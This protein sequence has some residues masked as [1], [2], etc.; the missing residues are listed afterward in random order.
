MIFSIVVYCIVL[1]IF[2]IVS[3]R[4]EE[5]LEMK[6]VI[7]WSPILRCLMMTWFATAL[8]TFTWFHSFNNGFENEKIRGQ[9]GKN[10]RIR[11]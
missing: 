3:R 2:M 5:V 8:W 9:S 1:G 6:R 7:V 11:G 10:I 4:W